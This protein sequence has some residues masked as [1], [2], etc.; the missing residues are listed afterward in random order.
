MARGAD[1]KKPTD[2][3]ANDVEEAEMLDKQELRQQ[4]SL[5]TRSYNR[6]RE[7]DD[8]AFS[9]IDA[10]GM[11]NDTKPAP[12][13]RRRTGSVDRDSESRSHNT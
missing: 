13:Y 10:A 1:E 8:D 2:K 6:S 12:R 7:I 3:K 9:Y 4:A 11:Y 5:L